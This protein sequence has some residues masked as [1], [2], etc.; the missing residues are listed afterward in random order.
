MSGLTPLAHRIDAVIDGAVYDGR[1]V[2][3]VVLVTQNGERAYA[4]AAGHATVRR[5]LRRRSTRSSAWPR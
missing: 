4:R 2:G 5:A 3:T 1:I